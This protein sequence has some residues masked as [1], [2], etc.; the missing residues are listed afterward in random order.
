MRSAGGVAAVSRSSDVVEVPVDP[1]FGG[2]A[3]VFVKRY[4]YDRFGQTI[5]Q[6]FRGTLFGKSRARREFEFLTEMRRRQI[7][8][9]RP[10]AYGD[11]Y[12]RAFLRASFLI[13]EGAEGFQSLDLFGL[14]A[15]RRNSLTRSQRKE[16]A[17]GLAVTIRKMHDVGI[18]HGG[19]Y[20]RNILVCARPDSGYD[21]LL[22]D[23]DTHRRPNA[24][25]VSE[26]DVVADLSEVVAS[27]LALGQ[28]AGLLTL[29]TAYFQVSRL[30]T[31]QRKLTSRIIECAHT[32]APSERRR[33]AV[34]EA[35]GWLRLRTASVD[36][37]NHRVRA[38]RSVDDFFDSVS[39]CAAVSTPAPTASKAIRFSFS[40]TD[41]GNGAFDR[42]VIVDG[43]RV[44]VSAVRPVRHDL[45]IR[46]DPETWLAVISGHADAYARLRSGR[47]RM[48]GDP[49]ILRT[50]MELLDRRESCQ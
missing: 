48:E 10:I 20:W 24:S 21:F 23:P 36:R 40:G 44:T 2:P 6:A 7:P 25:R 22:I 41:G 35:I 33:M 12:G 46:T 5:K 4:R 13:T 18:R 9:V 31:E 30:T 42:T 17:K 50:L 43:E 3:S 1:A 38:F 11:D 32:L 29:M 37:G 28:R 26:S 14:D 8:T 45:V 15:L 47:L 49:I 27:A 39:S 34:A 19:L 16:L